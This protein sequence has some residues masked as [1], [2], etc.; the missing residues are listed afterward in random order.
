MHVIEAR[1]RLQYTSILYNGC[2]LTCVDLTTS[3]AYN[4]TQD[5]LKS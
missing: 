5:D 2:K 4:D 3:H 1:Q